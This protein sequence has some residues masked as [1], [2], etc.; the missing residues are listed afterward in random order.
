MAGK[1]EQMIADELDAVKRKREEA[2]NNINR[3]ERQRSEWDQVLTIELAEE[4]ELT[5][6]LEAI[7]KAG[8]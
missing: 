8:L 5:L 6:A 3:L 7:R 4:E 1:A 2:Q